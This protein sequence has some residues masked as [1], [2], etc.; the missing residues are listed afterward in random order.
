MNGAS[1]SRQS[2]RKT[3][4]PYS[5]S[6]QSDLSPLRFAAGVVVD[7]AVDD[8]P[9]AVVA[10]GHLP[11]GQV[12]AV[13]ERDETRRARS[14]RRRQAGETTSIRA[15]RKCQGVSFHASSWFPI[16]GQIA[17]SVVLADCQY[18]GGR[19]IGYCS[20]AAEFVPEPAAAGPWP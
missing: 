18:S 5:R 1:L 15:E 10:L 20:P 19:P 11:A 3:K 6:L 13:E 9:V 14:R 16:H 2:S 8:L 17:R 12:L 7:D 4:S